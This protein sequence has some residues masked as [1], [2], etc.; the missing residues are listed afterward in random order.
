LYRE[1]TDAIVAEMQRYC[2]S[3][4]PDCRSEPPQAL[5]LELARRGLIE[6]RPQQRG[7][8]CATVDLEGLA[9]TECN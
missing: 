9:M 1:S 3:G 6:P 4:P 8:E 5:L 7:I 2:P